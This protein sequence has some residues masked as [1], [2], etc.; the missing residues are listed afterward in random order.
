MGRK[1]LTPR[2]YNID[3]LAYGYSYSLNAKG[4]QE[5]LCLLCLKCRSNNSMTPAKLKFHLITAH[6]KQKDSLNMT[7]LQAKHSEQM[8]KN[9]ENYVK[10][11][12]SLSVKLRKFNA[13][14][15]FKAAEIIAKG[16][17]Y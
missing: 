10:F 16:K 7:D 6:V 15:S 8:V 17:F 2:Y 4:I 14:M 13:L 9:D 5:P 3:Y 1:H 12:D 11:G